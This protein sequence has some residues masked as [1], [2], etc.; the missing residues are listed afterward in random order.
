[1]SM[2]DSCAL[3]LKLAELMVDMQRLIGIL[4]SRHGWMNSVPGQERLDQV[5]Q[6]FGI[7]RLK[8]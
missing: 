5:A 7:D 1:M 4:P 8:F 3:T 6:F 2:M